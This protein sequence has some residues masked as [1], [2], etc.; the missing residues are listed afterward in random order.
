MKKRLW[1]IIILLAIIFTPINF[2][3]SES[4]MFSKISPPIQKQNV[5]DPG[6]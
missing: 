6:W 5:F 4:A 3:D 2:A 1:E